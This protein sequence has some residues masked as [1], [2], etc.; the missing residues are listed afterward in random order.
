MENNTLQV[1]NF[2]DQSL[3]SLE[4]DYTTL[5]EAETIKWDVEQLNQLNRKYYDNKISKDQYERFKTK[6]IDSIDHFIIE[7]IKSQ[8]STEQSK[9]LESI[10]NAIGLYELGE[11][12]YKARKDV[13]SQISYK[14]IRAVSWDELE[15][16]ELKEKS[17]ILEPL[18]RKQDIIMIYAKQGVG[19]TQV[20]T[21]IAWAISSG[22]EF[23]GWS[24]TRQYKTLFIDGE[25]PA[26]TIRER[27]RK[28]NVDNISNSNLKFIS[29]DTLIDD[30]LMPDLS[31]SDG[32]EAIESLTNW[33]DFIVLD[34]LATLCRSGKENTTEAWRNTQSWLLNL[35]A[36]GKT[37]LVVDHAG[38]NGDNRGA[39][40]KKDVLDTIIC[41]KEPA[42]REDKNNTHFIINIE[43]NRNANHIE[44]IEAYLDN[45]GT[46]NVSSAKQ[47]RNEQ[48]ISL[49]EE[50]L[51]QREIVEEMGCSLGTVNRVIK[52]HKQQKEYIKK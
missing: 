42:N 39:S 10:D 12:V 1:D 4:L 44:S 9:Q 26:I 51:N 18:I 14:N 22:T 47:S 43:K 46:W 40:A 8:L 48:I 34:N 25:M 31:T 36:K 52:A 30:Q 6:Y 7:S 50:G 29:N 3:K 35:R 45:S 33:A 21:G 5:K 38:K 13:Y 11:R 32:Q 20:S 27:I 2:I 23:L 17:F 37:I 28:L 16:M 15:E 41:L 24:A 19:K 49:C